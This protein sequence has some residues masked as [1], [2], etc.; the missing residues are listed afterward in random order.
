MLAAVLFVLGIMLLRKPA[1]ARAGNGLAAL[2]MAIA[3]AFGV[4]AIPLHHTLMI[5]IVFAAAAAAGAVVARIVKMTAMPQLVALF[6][7]MGGG[8]AALVA[9]VVMLH[10]TGT[11]GRLPALIAIPGFFT[12][13]IGSVSFAGSLVAF[14]KLQEWLSGRPLLFRG[15]HL[16]NLV[17][18]LAALAAGLAA[19]AG[20]APAPPLAALVGGLAVL[21]GFLFVL[22]VGGADMPVIISFLNS[23]TGLAAAATGFV[24]SSDLLIVA[25]ALVGA[26]GTILTLIMSRA[27]HRSLFS[28]LFAGFGQVQAGAGR[29]DGA[30]HATS[31]DE[32]ATLLAYS[33]RVVIVPGYGMA[34]A[35]AQLEVKDLADRLIERGVDVRFGIH[36]VAG[37]MPGHM[38][39]LLAEA[40]V[41]YDRL[42]EMERINP[43]FARTDVVLVIG[44]NDVTNPAARTNPGSP[45]YGMPVLEVD[46][47]AA[48]V[49]LKRSMATGFAGVDNPLF[50]MDKTLMLFG[51]ARESVAALVQE[52]REAV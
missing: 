30:M 19:L 3:L 29:L 27:M 16:L 43:E 9:L 37:R 35:R 52:L 25:G 36:P 50:L 15:Q 48:I 22:P 18:L 23:L 21:L 12:L 38:N 40:N 41:P 10:A 51:D 4:L 1:T 28:A 5:A 26:S 31:A 44:A 7:G 32:V 45:I 14:A 13:L 39:V 11:G 8:A 34:V 46:Q 20:L 17:V 6:N 33:R 24:L 49:V 47:A 2:G 42:Y